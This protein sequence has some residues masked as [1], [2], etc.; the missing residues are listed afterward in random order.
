MKRIIMAGILLGFVA[1]AYSSPTPPQYLQLCDNNSEG[2][3]E[4]PKG[5]TLLIEVVMPAQYKFA[6]YIGIYIHQLPWTGWFVIY[7]A[8]RQLIWRW[9]VTSSMKKGWFDCY[10]GK[11][12]GSGRTFYVGAEFD[13]NHLSFGTDMDPPYHYYKNW[14][15][16][17]GG[18]GYSESWQHLSNLEDPMIRVQVVGSPAVEPTSLGRVKAIYR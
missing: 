5:T 9:E 14:I 8:E 12:I 15:R 4:S 18:P 7:N 10:V 2:E 6:E 13:Y 3:V 16:Y 17:P 11:Y 1:L